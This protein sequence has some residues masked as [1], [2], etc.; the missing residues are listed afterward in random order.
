MPILLDDLPASHPARRGRSRRHRPVECPACKE[1][2]IG[3][4]GRDLVLQVVPDA[5]VAVLG[6]AVFKVGSPP[7]GI[8][9]ERSRKRMGNADPTAERTTGWPRRASCAHLVDWKVGA[10]SMIE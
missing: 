2:F 7:A 3:H 1:W 5:F 9:C 8:A 4:F 10:G 6:R